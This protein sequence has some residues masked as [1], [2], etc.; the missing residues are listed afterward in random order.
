MDY[1]SIRTADKSAAYV[2]E[3]VVNTDADVASIP[4]DLIAPGS[5]CIV[6]GNASVYMLNTNKE[7]I[8][9]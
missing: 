9:L 3:F 2:E 7:W 4:V 5:T 6:I 8:L 1:F